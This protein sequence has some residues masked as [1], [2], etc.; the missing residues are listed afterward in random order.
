[1][2]YRTIFKEIQVRTSDATPFE[3]KTVLSYL[4]AGWRIV[5]SI[6]L[7]RDRTAIFLS[8]RV[9]SFPIPLFVKKLTKET[10]ATAFR[11]KT[12]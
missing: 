1:M 10:G 6:Q 12:G 3:L 9:W 2:V 4:R 5:G 8:R 7:H 11:I